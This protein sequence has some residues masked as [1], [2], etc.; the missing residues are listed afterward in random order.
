MSGQTGR[1]SVWRRKET[2]SYF[3]YE[4]I[5]GGKGREGGGSDGVWGQ[6]R[7]QRRGRLK[8]REEGGENHEQHM[9]RRD[10]VLEQRGMSAG[11]ERESMSLGYEMREGMSAVSVPGSV[12]GQD[13]GLKAVRKA[14]QAAGAYSTSMD[15]HI[16]QRA[17]DREEC[18]GQTEMT[19]GGRRAR[20]SQGRER[21]RHKGGTQCT[22]LSIIGLMRAWRVG[23]RVRK[24]G[25]EGTG[26]EEE[27]DREGR[28][29]GKQ[30]SSAAPRARG[31]RKRDEVGTG[32]VEGSEEM[33]NNV[34]D[35]MC[36][37]TPP[38]R[39][40]CRP[41]LFLDKYMLIASSCASQSD[42]SD[43]RGHRYFAGLRLLA[44]TAVFSRRKCDT[45][46]RNPN[47][48]RTQKMNRE[49]NDFPFPRLLK[50]IVPW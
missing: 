31:A 43:E 49:F 25:G 36:I 47:R 11:E 33:R 44:P 19:E 40:L 37:A 22:G 1:E 24:A 17:A 10:M 21:A 38:V 39:R 6:R 28:K 50:L 30:G 20:R 2:V 9:W 42:S 13:P 23:K 7:G 18:G 26:S 14:A 8:G 46:T 4:G 15:R 27:G 32:M 16:V 3:T 45:E 34:G 29:K 35:A 41:L 12:G 5:K 48:P